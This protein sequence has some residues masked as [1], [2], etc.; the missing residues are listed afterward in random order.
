[1]KV[2]MLKFAF[3]FNEFLRTAATDIS[4]VLLTGSPHEH[5]C[6]LKCSYKLLLQQENNSSCGECVW[7]A[8]QAAQTCCEE[9]AEIPG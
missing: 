7:E 2:K 5:T 4:M 1:M 3:F 6:Q 8:K 9:E